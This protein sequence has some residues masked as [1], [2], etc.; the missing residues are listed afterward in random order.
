M[1]CHYRANIIYPGMSSVLLVLQYPDPGFAE[2]EYVSRAHAN[3][4]IHNP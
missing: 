4:N 2:T 3:G 1:N